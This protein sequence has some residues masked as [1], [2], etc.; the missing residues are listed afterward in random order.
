MKD[1][2]LESIAKTKKKFASIR[3]VIDVDP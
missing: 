2:V 3:V 1:K